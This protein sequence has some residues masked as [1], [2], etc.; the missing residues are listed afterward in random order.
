M[1]NFLFLKNLGPVHG[2]HNKLGV[3][4]YAKLTTSFGFTVISEEKNAAEGQSQESV[5]WP[6]HPKIYIYDQVAHDQLLIIAVAL[7]LRL[8]TTITKRD[9]KLLVFEAV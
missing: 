8:P 9:Q 2:K 7:I 3:P 1:G 6:C 5:V 4:K